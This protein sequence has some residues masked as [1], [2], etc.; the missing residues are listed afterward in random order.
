MKKKC[1]K[2]LKIALTTSSAFA[3]SKTVEYLKNNY[4]SYEYSIKLEC[5]T[6][7]PGNYSERIISESAKLLDG[8]VPKDKIQRNKYFRYQNVIFK[9]IINDK[10]EHENSQILVYSYHYKHIKN[11]INII[12]SNKNKML[13][14]ECLIASDYS[15]Y[16]NY[17]KYSD[18]YKTINSKI[19]VSKHRK[20]IDKSIENFIKTNSSLKILLYGKPGTGKTSAFKYIINKS[21][22][23]F[24]I[25]NISSEFI[26]QLNFSVHDMG[27]NAFLTNGIVR[28]SDMSNII[29][30]DEIDLI[31][32]NDPEK[33]LATLT[34]L[35][36][37]PNKTII[38]M[39]TNNYESL[40]E[41]FKRKGRVDLA[42][43]LSDFD[44]DEYNEYLSLSNVNSG[45]VEELLKDPSYKEK[46]KGCNKYNPSTLESI[47]KDIKKERA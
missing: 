11:F 45:E 22:I 31:M 42:L 13:N 21:N 46:Y 32:D 1:K 27:F 41:Q 40:P 8:I 16:N 23:R 7:E 33:I 47:V 28:D 10:E 9:I 24:N 25:I 26:N 19:F 6:Y 29:L 2:Y 30:L 18:I 36:N 43:E 15:H 44:T 3:I 34:V 4:F 5:K 37:I 38:V 14:D 12:R 17:F 20:I 35:S 39:T